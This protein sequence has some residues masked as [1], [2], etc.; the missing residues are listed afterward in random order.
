MQELHIISEAQKS[1]L[2][3]TLEE[4]C[5]LILPGEQSGLETLT[6]HIYQ[7]KHHQN[8][9]DRRIFL[10][11]WGLH[12]VFQKK[13]LPEV[14]A[15]E[16]E[17]QLKNIIQKNSVPIK[18]ALFKQCRDILSDAVTI[19]LEPALN[20]RHILL[21]S[22]SLKICNARKSKEKD[23]NCGWPNYCIFLSWTDESGEFQE[24]IYPLQFN[25]V[26]KQF[27]IPADEIVTQFIR[28]RDTQI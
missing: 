20:E 11:R 7:K 18:Q 19:E 8:R 27:R 13:H 25:K 16:L 28:Y 4:S 3:K 10:I 21:S 17:T 24:F 15:Q 14:P 9:S 2:L 23:S 5:G 6:F 1:V 22:S 12:Q 26:E